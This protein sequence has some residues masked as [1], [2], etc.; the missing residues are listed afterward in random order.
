VSSPEYFPSAAGTFPRALWRTVE[1]GETYQKSQNEVPY[2]D[3]GLFALPADDEDVTTRE[4]ERG[5][6]VWATAAASGFV[7]GL[8][9]PDVV[10]RDLTERT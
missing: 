1:L 10:V 4:P 5:L 9:S 2:L 7:E 8:N 6:R 3:G